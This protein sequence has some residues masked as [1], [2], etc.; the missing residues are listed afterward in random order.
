M[1]NSVSIS[2]D[3]MVNISSNVSCVVTVMLSYTSL[4]ELAKLS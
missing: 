4:S 1:K 2:T 3:T